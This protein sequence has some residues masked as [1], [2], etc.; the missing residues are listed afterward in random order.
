MN[1]FF[2]Y[3]G[4]IYMEKKKLK[5]YILKKKTKV[6]INYFVNLSCFVLFFFFFFF[7]F[8]WREKLEGKENGSPTQRRNKI[9]SSLSHTS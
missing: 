2:L 6:T 5:N 9:K 8:F 7:F 1:V 4:Y 3:L